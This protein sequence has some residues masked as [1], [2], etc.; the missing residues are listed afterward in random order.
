[1]GGTPPLSSNEY[2]EAELAHPLN[3][4]LVLKVFGLVCRG[5]SQEEQL[6]R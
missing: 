3:A 4:L 2:R 1:M 5:P 6:I